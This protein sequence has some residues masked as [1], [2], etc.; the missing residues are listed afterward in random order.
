MWRIISD[1]A[2]VISMQKLVRVKQAAEAAAGGGRLVLM[3]DELFKGTNVKDAYDGTLA[4][5]EAFSDYRECLVHCIHISL[6]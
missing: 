1:W 3:F 6:K 4:V 5:T 2:I